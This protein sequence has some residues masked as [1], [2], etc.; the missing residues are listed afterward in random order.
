MV[1]DKLK[2]ATPLAPRRMAVTV[3][4][5]IKKKLERLHDLRQSAASDRELYLQ[6]SNSVQA[7][8]APFGWTRVDCPATRRLAVAEEYLQK[9]DEAIVNWEQVLA[10]TAETFLA[11]GYDVFP[12]ESIADNYN[13]PH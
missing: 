7:E 10:F 12:S 2:L 6:E 11:S 4:N 5:E 9:L 8:E 1:N 13:A 3:Y